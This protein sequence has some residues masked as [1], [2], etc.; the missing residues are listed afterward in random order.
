[1][2]P[3]IHPQ[4]IFP[5]SALRAPSRVV[6]ERLELRAFT[7]ADHPDYARFCA[8][9]EVMQYMG[10]GKANTP[11]ITWR[12]MA[13]ML[14]HW[15]LLGYGIWALALRDGGPLVGHVGFIDVPG[16]PGFELA[17]MLGKEHWGQGYAREGAAAALRVA[18]GDL[19]RERVISLIRP[20]NT[21]SRRL[22]EHLGA[23]REQSVE[24]MG[25]E[26]DLFVH[27]PEAK[28]I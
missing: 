3:E 1:M 14:G 18:F 26:A 11:D 17:Y 9:P 23:L 13:G 8:D 24:L 12:S 16:W 10:A 4:S 22:V 19:R 7:L 6:T 21:A 25:S 15:D 27:R 5:T 20:A 2:R 28:P